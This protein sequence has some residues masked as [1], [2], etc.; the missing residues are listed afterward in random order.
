MGFGSFAT[1][2]FTCG[3]NSHPAPLSQRSGQKGFTVSFEDFWNQYPRKVCKKPARQQWE[4]LTADEQ[5]KAIEALPAHVKQWSDPQFIPHARTWLYQERWEDEIE[6]VQHKVT[7]W[8]SS[9]S[10]ME[11]KARELGVQAAPG[12]GYD[13]LKEKIRRR[14]AA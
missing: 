3:V 8:W 7:A 4:K 1:T 6:P 12:E 5:R 10:A 9:P 11:A 14:L 13:Q 2:P